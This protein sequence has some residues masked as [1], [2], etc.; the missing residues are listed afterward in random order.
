MGV[1]DPFWKRSTGKDTNLVLLE[2]SPGRS[3]KFGLLVRTVSSS[4]FTMFR[5]KIP[6]LETFTF[7]KYETSARKLRVQRYK[8]GGDVCREVVSSVASNIAWES[9]TKWY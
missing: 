9:D 3:N 5:L 2:K 7:K 8:E 6:C 4:F 1:I